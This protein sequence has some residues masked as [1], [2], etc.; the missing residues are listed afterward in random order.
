MNSFRHLASFFKI[1][2]FRPRLL[3]CYVDGA[4]W[5]ISDSSHLMI[6]S[7]SCLKKILLKAYKLTKRR[8]RRYKSK[9]RY[10]KFM[11]RHIST[12]NC[13]SQLEVQYAVS[14]LSL[15]KVGRLS[16]KKFWGY[17]PWHGWLTQSKIAKSGRDV[18]IL[19]VIT[20]QSSMPVLGFYKTV[21]FNFSSI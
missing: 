20:S 13:P 15:S 3:C 1:E 12:W 2:R 17:V 18:E 4:F 14:G 9:P 19:Q 10:E 21:L 7:Q 8:F 16:H 6:R 11:L 5:A